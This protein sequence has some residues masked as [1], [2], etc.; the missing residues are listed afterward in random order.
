VLK[1][2]QIKFLFSYLYMNI[3][4]HILFS[5]FFLGLN[6]L[7]SFG[8]IADFTATIK[9][10]TV[11]VP[12]NIPFNAPT[13]FIC[14]VDSIQFTDAS[15]GAPTA[16]E[17]TFPNGIP[18]SYIGQNP[19]VVKYNLS[20]DNVSTVT[21]KITKG[22]VVNTKTFLLRIL[23]KP[24]AAFYISTLNQIAPATVTFVNNSTNFNV[25]NKWDFGDGNTSVADPATNTYSSVGI[26][27]VCIVVSKLSFCFDSIC[28]NLNIEN[29][30]IVTMPNTF[31]PDDDN[32]NTNELFKPIIN[33]GI[34][35]MTCSIF[36]RWG[37]L[38]YAWEG[39]KGYW[40]GYT[41]GGQACSTGTYYYKLSAKSE[42][43][44]AINVE[45]Y[46][47]LVR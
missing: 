38:I 19:P 34:K 17:W 45:G 24:T 15:S 10:G 47:Q 6:F 13:G 12:T 29:G 33:V 4:R 1:F 41:T 44:K 40:D 27:K 23:I 26:Y 20:V 46:V 35:S 43:D 22:A 18:S 21:L 9:N 28:E 3:S 31:T 32:A 37:N 39:V 8:Q 42:D 7:F 5:V 16:W 25:L 30:A 2:K 14:N 11:N 36:D